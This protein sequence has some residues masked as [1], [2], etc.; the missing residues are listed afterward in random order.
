[1]SS[2]DDDDFDEKRERER[3]ATVSNSASF[4][5]SDSMKTE[6]AAH[7]LDVVEDHEAAC[8]TVLSSSNSSHARIITMAR[9]VADD[10]VPDAAVVPQLATAITHEVTHEESDTCFHN[11]RLNEG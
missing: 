11:G 9:I 6:V 10:R 4:L 8:R 3:N 5:P 7:K 2:G 1:M